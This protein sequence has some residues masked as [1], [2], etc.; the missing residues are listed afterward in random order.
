MYKNNKN[1]YIDKQ[2]CT[3]LLVCLC[4]TITSPSTISVNITKDN[5]VE[6]KQKQ[7]ELIKQN[8]EKIKD[9]R[10]TV[11]N[12]KDE[13]KNKLDIDNKI[14]HVKK[15]ID[16]TNVYISELSSQ[17]RELEIQIEETK[18]I[19][20]E[21]IELLKEALVSIYVAG[22]TMAI[23]IILGAKDFNDFLD[24]ADIVRSV[25]GTI[26]E[27][28]DSLKEYIGS[29]ETKQN[30]VLEIKEHEKAELKKSEASRAELQKL[31]EESEKLLSE[32]EKTQK[33]FQKEIDEN[34]SAIRKLNAEIK[35]YYE[36]E[37]RR[38][39]EERRKNKNYV[40]PVV[41]TSNFV[42]PVPG[43]S[44]ITSY[45]G[46][47]TNRTRPHNGLDIAGAGVYGAP[48]VA[49]TSGTVIAVN[50]VVDANGQGGGG[51]GKYVMI[52]HGNKISTLYGHLSVVSVSKGQK[53]TK[54]QTIGNVGSTGFST[55]PHL[56]FEVRID[57][58]R[59]D[60]LAYVNVP[61]SKKVKKP[62]VSI[63]NPEPVEPITN[64]NSQKTSIAG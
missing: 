5:I 28:I 9:I 18:Q 17:I 41:D 48:V 3:S 54:G 7:N 20:K 62:E 4:S 53:V 42:W 60:P 14:A 6:Y 29:L 25:G 22:D 61:G 44:K 1:K 35:K 26:K 50:S 38:I 64:K 36:E 55:G 23:D 56:H 49:V 58:I 12:I 33:Q 10:N 13:K 31:F 40:E 59:K 52:A 30:R 63:K 34:D 15:E 21:K 51:Y 19:I 2:I 16:E 45:F 32:Y 57:N 37:R 27:L 39:E 47:K 8:K 46:E 43:Y 24:K 11:K